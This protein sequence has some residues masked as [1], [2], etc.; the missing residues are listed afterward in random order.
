MIA[1]GGPRRFAFRMGDGQRDEA[2]VIVGLA[3]VRVEIVV[4]ERLREALVRGR[5]AGRRGRD[6]ERALGHLGRQCVQ[7]LLIDRVGLRDLGAGVA[8]LVEILQHDGDVRRVAVE[9]EHV[10]PGAE[11]LIDLRAERRLVLVVDDRSHQLGAVLP[12]LLADDLLRRQRERRLHGQDSDALAALR[13]HELGELPPLELCV[14]LR[15]HEVA[16]VRQQRDRV[17]AR[18]GGE[19][20]LRFPAERRDRRRDRGGPR[21]HDRGDLVE[22]DQ[23]ARRPH[24][25]LGI[26]L[27]VL[28]DEL[29]L[30][31]EHAAGGVDLAGHPLHRLEHRGTVVTAGA[32]ERRQ[33]AEPDRTCLGAHARRNRGH[34]ERSDADLE[35]RTTRET[36][37]HAYPPRKIR[38]TSGSRASSAAGPLLLLRPS[39]RI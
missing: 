5:L 39:T 12:E 32:G 9:V 8:G 31:A 30:A 17:R 11:H 33:R 21:A 6:R 16:L 28:A 27:V 20:R 10:G 14:G 36:L 19:E 29:E 25:G 37:S 4:A 13:H 38:R 15:P 18:H 3:R 7:Q 1:D 35:K 23:L 22:I 24:P 34:G 26:R 2:D